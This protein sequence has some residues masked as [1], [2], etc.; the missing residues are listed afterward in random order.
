MDTTDTLAMW[1]AWQEAQKLSQRTI[2]D[3]ALIVA[4]LARYVG[5]PAHLLGPDELIAFLRRRQLSP[6]SAHTYYVALTAYFGW[7][8]AVGLREDNPCEKLPKIRRKAGKP[9]PISNAEAARLLATVNRR[10]T[11]MMVL[12]GMFAGLRAHEI[13]KIRGEDVDLVERTL[14]VVGKGGAAEVVPLHDRIAEYASQ[15]PAAGFWFPSGSGH[16]KRGAVSTTV[17]K[18]MRRAGIAEGSAHRLRHWYGSELSRQGVDIRV[19]QEL[20]RHESIASTQIY[21]HVDDSRRR[22]GIGLLAA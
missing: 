3:R 22:A 21:T 7:L 8:V 12:L 2:T 20:M 13:A 4:K 16:I 14:F 18:A 1:R 19:V 17:G 15:F 9:R 5:Q 10:K 6:N 11:R